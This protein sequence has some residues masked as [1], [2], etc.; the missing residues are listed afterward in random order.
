[1]NNIIKIIITEDLIRSNLTELEYSALKM[2]DPNSNTIQACKKLLLEYVTFIDPSSLYFYHNGFNQNL[3]E[4]IR[5]MIEALNLKDERDI[6]I[7][8]FWAFAADDNHYH[9]EIY[10]PMSFSIFNENYFSDMVTNYLDGILEI[11]PYE[12]MKQYAQDSHFNKYEIIEVIK[13]HEKVAMS[14]LQIINTSI[15]TDLSPISPDDKHVI[16]IEKNS[17]N[18]TICVA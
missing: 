13:P 9:S 7:F 6:H 4:K 3:H 11:F 17:Y 10:K 1:M 14:L 12:D 18:L 2:L 5:L 15:L 16:Y 8:N